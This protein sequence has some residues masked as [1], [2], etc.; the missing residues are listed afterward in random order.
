MENEMLHTLWYNGNTIF[1][2]CCQVS[3]AISTIG[4]I[5]NTYMYRDIVRKSWYPCFKA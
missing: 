3:L 2:Y 5:N 4:S 1:I